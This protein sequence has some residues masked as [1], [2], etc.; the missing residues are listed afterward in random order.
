MKCFFFSAGQANATYKG[1]VKLW[2]EV[3]DEL[4]SVIQNQLV[5]AQACAPEVKTAHFCSFLLPLTYKFIS[6]N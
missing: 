3:Y 1:A 4:R 5:A 6:E 2:F